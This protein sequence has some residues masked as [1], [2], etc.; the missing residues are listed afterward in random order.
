MPRGIMGGK[1]GILIYL[2]EG[3]PVGTTRPRI[4]AQ[5]LMVFAPLGQKCLEVE[6]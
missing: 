1:Q 4:N 3:S 2:L 6:L 5:Y